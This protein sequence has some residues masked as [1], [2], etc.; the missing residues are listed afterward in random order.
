MRLGVIGY[1]LWGK[2]H[3]DALAKLEDV[4]LSAISCRSEETADRVR[5]DYPDMPVYLDYTNLL[6]RDDIDAVTVVVPNYLHAEVGIA[7][8]EAGKDV[9]LEKPMAATA[10]RMRLADCSGRAKQSRAD[11]W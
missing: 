4:E 6:A 2:R 9:L 8:L 1:G 7:A 3:A 5:Q 10:R 11:H